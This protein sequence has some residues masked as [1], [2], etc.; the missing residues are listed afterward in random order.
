M[1]TKTVR[2]QLVAFFVIAVVAVVYA[3]FRF[4]DL[5]RVFGADGYRVKMDLV[6]S[7]GIFTNAEVT[8]RGVNVG[9]VGEIKL[10]REG[11]RIDLEI[12][13]SAPDIPADLDAVV[14]NRSAVGEQYVDLRP[15]KDGGEVLK[16][17]SVIPADRTKTPISTDEVIRDLDNLATSV[18]TD[19]LR[20]VVDELE[21]A[22][23]GT[24][25]DLQ[26]LLDNQMAFTQTAREHLPQTIK[27]I[28]DGAIVLNTQMKQSGNIK[29]FAGDLKALSAQLRE[30][31]PQIRTLIAATPGAADS[32]TGLLRES[33]NGLGAVFAN[34]L[35]VSNIMVTRTDGL[36]LALVAY[37]LVAVGPKTVIDEKGQTHLGLALNLFDPPPCTRGYEG[38]ERRDGN[39]TAP[40][41]VNEQAY[42]AEPVGSPI[43]V[44]GSANAPF[45]GKPVAPTQE[46]L[47]ANQNRDSEQ[48]HELATN[49]IP[50]T[51][52]QPGIGGLS[53]LA[54]LLGL[55]A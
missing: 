17:G 49:S 16:E 30:S 50:G 1:L 33:G 41:P 23:S 5:G 34:L 36:E 38:T 44:R 12:E 6:Q 29:S 25:D 19:S 42:C 51:V 2:L 8:Y 37:P 28:E 54:G 40:A 3:A 11:M 20:T 45:G 13:P 32:I 43:N 47:A 26:V 18:P 22:F 46:Q 10:T 24:G 4:T 35:T 53:G 21:R 15:R 27:L 52:T 7:G 39:E 48:L 55:P 31:D 14:A 9:R